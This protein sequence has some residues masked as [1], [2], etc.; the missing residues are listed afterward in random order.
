MSW[1]FRLADR[2]V[3]LLEDRLERES[4]PIAEADE[5]QF[6]AWAERYERAVRANGLDALLA[7]GREI[8]GWLGPAW[9]DRL[10]GGAGPIC[11]DIETEASPAAPARAFLDVPWELMTDASSF[12]ALDPA[13]TFCVQRRLGR[14][15]TPVAAKHKE[16]FA[17]FMA[18]SPRDVQPVLDYEAEEAGILAATEGLPL[19][20]TV[21]ESGCLAFLRNRPCRSRSPISSMHS[22]PR[23][24]IPGSSPIS[25][26]CSGPR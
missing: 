24:V 16:L 20:L 7:I 17:M 4:R 10:T 19:A 12:L 5:L 3:F 23:S 13:R 18:A 22:S 11:L 9:M 25:K 2:R 26:T 21:E 6:R 8:S 15:A 14:Q 1:T